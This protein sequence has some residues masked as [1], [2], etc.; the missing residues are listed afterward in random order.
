MFAKSYLLGHF[1]YTTCTQKVRNAAVP[2]NLALIRNHA[3]AI[4]YVF[5][6]SIGSIQKHVK[7]VVTSASFTG[8]L[9]GRGVLGTYYTSAS[10]DTLH[11]INKL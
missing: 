9:L 1:R 2:N 7:N 3:D 10:R 5:F 6:S 4:V 8:I 11:F